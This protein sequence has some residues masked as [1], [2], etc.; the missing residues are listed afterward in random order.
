MP[1]FAF[2][3]EALLNYRRNRRDLC[4]NLLAQLIADDRRLRDLRHSIEADRGGQFDEMRRLGTV[5][6][7]DVDGS[8]SRRYYAGQLLAEIAKVEQDR[9]LVERQVAM[10]RHALV[11]ADRQVKVLEKLA[12]KQRAEFVYEENRKS[13]RELEDVW[14]TAQLTEASR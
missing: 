4:R 6:P 3:F 1:R 8:V 9:Q 12:E 14:Q 5:G 11:E 7:V 10:C 2:R 13:A